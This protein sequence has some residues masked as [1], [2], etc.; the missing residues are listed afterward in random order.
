MILPAPKPGTGLMT[1]AFDLDGT[2]AEPTWPSPTIGK[3]IQR[4]VDAAIEYFTRGNEIIIFTSRPASHR[5]AIASWLEEHGLEDVVYDI[6]T[7]K[8]RAAAYVDDRAITFPEAFDGPA[9]ASRAVGEPYCGDP[10][11]LLCGK[12]SFPP[13]VRTS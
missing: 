10:R 11:C 12:S 1:I 3:P 5:D 6:V 2:L 8:P 7:D 9:F 13:E 4:A